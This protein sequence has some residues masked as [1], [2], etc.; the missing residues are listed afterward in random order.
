MLP[1]V[2]TLLVTKSIGSS[3]GPQLARRRRSRR[4]EASTV[5][6]LSIL[7][8]RGSCHFYIYCSGARRDSG[9]IPAEV[10]SFGYRPRWPRVEAIST[11]PAP[12]C[13]RYHIPICMP[14][15]LVKPNPRNPPQPAPTRQ[16]LGWVRPSNNPM[17][18]GYFW[19]PQSPAEQPAGLPR[20]LNRYIT[21]FRLYLL[22]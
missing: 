6:C 18:F 10:G 13:S 8:G 5:A 2:V 7:P 9:C 4:P 3:R 11:S 21:V 19:L 17:G 12:I 14:A 16:E 20:Y 22:T 1:D 15:R